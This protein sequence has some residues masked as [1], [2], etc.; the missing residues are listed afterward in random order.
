MVGSLRLALEGGDEEGK[1]GMNE[2][3]KVK[4]RKGGNRLRMRKGEKNGKKGRKTEGINVSKMRKYGL[5][6]ILEGKGNI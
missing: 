3:K 2:E 4:E 5:V 6:G 1:E